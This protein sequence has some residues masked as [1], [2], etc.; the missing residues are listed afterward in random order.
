MTVCAYDVHD[1]RMTV[2][3]RKRLSVELPGK[4]RDRVDELAAVESSTVTEVIRRALAL[5]DLFVA[6]RGAGS[7]VVVRSADGTERELVVL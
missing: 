6:A 2:P 1:S 3:A 7:T 4:I 5:Y